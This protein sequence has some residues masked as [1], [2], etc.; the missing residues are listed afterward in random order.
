MQQ[1]QTAPVNSLPPEILSNIFLELADSL[2]NYESDRS[3]QR[4]F[5][6]SWIRVIRVCR[7]WSDVAIEQPFLWNIIDYTE[8]PA[9]QRR[10][11]AAFNQQWLRRARYAPLDICIWRMDV[12]GEEALADLA[13][14]CGQI[15]KLWI[16]ISDR[17]DSLSKLLTSATQLES[18]TIHNDVTTHRLPTLFGGDTPSLRQLVFSGHALPSESNRFRN[19]I[20]L[21]LEHQFYRMQRDCIAFLEVLHSSPG[22]EFLNIRKCR[23]DPSPGATEVDAFPVGRDLFH[24]PHL[25]DIGFD[26]CNDTLTHAVLSRL[27]I[28]P[29]QSV[30]LR[31][32]TNRLPGMDLSAAFPP[33]NSSHIHP[34]HADIASIELDVPERLNTMNTVLKGPSVCIRL[35]CTE[36]LKLLGNIF[37]DQGAWV[38]VGLRDT[39]SFS[40]LES[41]HVRGKAVFLL[42]PWQDWCEVLGSMTSLTVLELDLHILSG[43]SYP[44]EWLTCLTGESMEALPYP[45]P[46]LHTLR[47]VP[48][49][50]APR[51][52]LLDMLKSRHRS[53]HKVQLLDILGPQV[54]K[55][56][57]NRRT[58]MQWKDDKEELMRFVEELSYSEGE[59]CE[60]YAVDDFAT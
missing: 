32:K 1:N 3:L 30:W 11:E 35:D 47:I 16:Q 40:C 10:R 25:E 51:N 37:E 59:S 14:R 27:D 8:K 31:Y 29:E 50:S 13:S 42:R 28:L 6:N 55:Y 49:E 48:P 2:A 7:R 21:E 45:V 39:F 38:F 54:D 12:I 53:G 19:L 34:V 60:P 15:Q 18:L 24:M 5:R 33:Q 43:P 22:L 4:G 57:P 58:L 26:Q 17:P 46:A 41:L 23:L 52:T 9:S 44:H 36:R 56:Q 20:R